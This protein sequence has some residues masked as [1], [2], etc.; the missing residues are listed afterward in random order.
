[1]WFRLAALWGCTVRE[2]MCRCDAREFAEWAALYSFDPWGPA[3]EDLQAAYTAA[4]VAKMFGAHGNP[5]NLL[6]SL[7]HRVQTPEEMQ[8]I[9]DRMVDGDRNI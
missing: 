4:A 1:M 8:A 6:L 9:L 3:R 5:G 7:K 2:A